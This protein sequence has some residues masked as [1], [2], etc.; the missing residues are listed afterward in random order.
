[1]A[2]RLVQVSASGKVV[3]GPVFLKSLVLAGGSD[4]ASVALADS[5]GAG[6]TAVLT[7]KAAAGSTVSW[8]SADKRGAFFGTA[9]YATV[10]GTS[11]AVSL[12]YER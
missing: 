9:I 4:A 7:L 1:M 10:S 8:H 11:P 2:S 5:S 12:E 3:D 6:G